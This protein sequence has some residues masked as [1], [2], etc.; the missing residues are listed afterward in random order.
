MTDSVQRRR[1]WPW[2][3][4]CVILFFVGIAGGLFLASLT[5]AHDF[6]VPCPP[7]FRPTPA[8]ME[9]AASGPGV[10]PP[11]PKTRPMSPLP[12]AG[13][14]AHVRGQ[15][16]VLARVEAD[17]SVSRTE[18]LRSSGFCPY[19]ISA[20]KDVRRW[21]FEPARRLGAAFAAWVPITVNYA[22]GPPPAARRATRDGVDI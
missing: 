16:V 17:G 15:V 3:T 11:R 4:A 19:D 7:L 18:L 13:R 12:R 9:A 1:R 22:L 20:L 14:M 5:M 2:I 8:E 21:S 10:F 6:G